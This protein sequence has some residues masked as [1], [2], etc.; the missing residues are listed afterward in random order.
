MRIISGQLKGRRANFK[1]PQ[2]IRPTS[3]FVRETIFNIL[4]NFFEIYGK[5]VLDLFSG[6][7]FLGFEALSRGAKHCSFVDSNINA[8]NFIKKVS[9]QFNIEPTNIEVIKADVIKFIKNP[10]LYSSLTHFDIVFCDPPYEMNVL[11]EILSNLI[12]SN[13]IHNE[14]ILVY[15][16]KSNFM[17]KFLYDWMLLDE[18]IMGDTKILFFGREGL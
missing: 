4:E 1:I 16:T 13:L 5:K 2:G 15:E 7:G 12:K 9:S 17:A 11:N 8:V 3:D 10:E 14:S 18:R 6:T